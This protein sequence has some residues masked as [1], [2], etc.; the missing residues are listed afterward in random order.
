[1]KFLLIL[2]NPMVYLYQLLNNSSEK[3]VVM[4]V[5][6]L[7]SSHGYHEEEAGNMVISG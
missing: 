4:Y 3:S 7:T 5:K 6:S 1:M 2:E